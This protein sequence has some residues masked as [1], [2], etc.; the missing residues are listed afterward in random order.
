[1]VPII[2]YVSENNKNVENSLHILNKSIHCYPQNT[3]A[4][5][6]SSIYNQKIN[7][8]CQYRYYL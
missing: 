7:E 5:K 4:L 6:L 3:F 2:D 8:S 1:M